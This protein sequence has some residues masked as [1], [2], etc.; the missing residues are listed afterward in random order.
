M[1]YASGS[2]SA[3]MGAASEA[4][5]LIFVYRCRLLQPGGGDCYERGVVGR[6]ARWYKHGRVSTLARGV[7]CALLW[8]PLAAYVR[9][10]LC[11]LEVVV[12]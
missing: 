4:I 11:R 7:M 3:V 10:N 6:S 2:D 8:S 5:T 12:V 1:V 9:P